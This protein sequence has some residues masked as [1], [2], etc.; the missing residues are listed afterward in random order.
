MRRLNP[1]VME[2][3]VFN[4]MVEIRIKFLVIKK[5]E[6]RIKNLALD[7]TYLMMEPPFTN[8]AVKNC[9]RSLHVH[10]WLLISNSSASKSALLFIQL[11]YSRFIVTVFQPIAQKVFLRISNSRTR[12]LFCNHSN[13]ESCAMRRMHAISGSQIIYHSKCFNPCKT[14]EKVM[15]QTVCLF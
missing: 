3:R 5:L 12:F 14:L 15:F 10:D 2:A 6:L 11:I 9:H 8:S 7:H 13:C 1:F 4:S